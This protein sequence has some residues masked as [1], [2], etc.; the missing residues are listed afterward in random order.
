[1]TV[2]LSSVYLK[3]SQELVIPGLISHDIN[4][5]HNNYQA[6]VRNATYNARWAMIT[7]RALELEIQV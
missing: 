2:P 3:I 6:L 1:M 4:I 7:G 5:H